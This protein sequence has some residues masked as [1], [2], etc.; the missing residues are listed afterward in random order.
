MKQSKFYTLAFLLVS[1]F[2]FQPVVAS[3]IFSTGDNTEIST[4]S[5][6]VLAKKEHRKIVRLEKRLAKMQRKLEK[7]SGVDFKDSVNKFM[8]FWILGWSL[9]LTLSILG[10]F[11]FGPLGWLAYAC[12]TAGS[13][14]LIIW[15]LKTLGAIS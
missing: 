8:W 6:P 3:A 12:W 5:T 2:L 15:I 10:A 9:G 14:C 13:V 7:A 11:V 1:A 4:N